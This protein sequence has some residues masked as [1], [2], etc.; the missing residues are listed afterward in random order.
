MPH[1]TKEPNNN[2]TTDINDSFNNNDPIKI[3]YRGIKGIYTQHDTYKPYTIFG[4]CD[5]ET[6]INNN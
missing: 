3:N 6:T 2:D 4:K 5:L 1:Q